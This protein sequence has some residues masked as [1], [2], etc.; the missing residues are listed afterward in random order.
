MTLQQPKISNEYT[1]G[2]EEFYLALQHCYIL[3][4]LTNDHLLCN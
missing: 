3:W 1:L 2:I 4:V